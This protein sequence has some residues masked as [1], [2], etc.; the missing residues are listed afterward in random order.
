MTTQGT[1]Q[2][3]IRV[4]IVDD[5]D[6]VRTGLAALLSISDDMQC[7]GE[8][9]D[10]AEAVE[11]CGRLRP[12]VVLMDLV[13]PGMDGIQ[14]TRLIRERYPDTQVLAL[15]SFEQEA[16][17]RGVLEAGAIGY[18]IKNITANRLAEAIRAAHAG[19]FSL[20]PEA[21]RALV[22]SDA[23]ADQAP[24]WVGQLTRRE[25]QVLQLMAQGFSNDEIAKRLSVSPATIQ[26]HIAHILSKLGAQSRAEATALALQH[27]LA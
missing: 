24:P 5:H 11:L 2:H 15:T 18:I 7:V 14:A 4:L 23:P 9:I 25:L 8:A 20:A 19:Q 13:M 16:L 3:L 12:D 1:H 26:E 21:A 17:V 6:M 22:R 27:G 10:G